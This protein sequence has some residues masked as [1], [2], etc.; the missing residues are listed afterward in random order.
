MCTNDL[1]LSAGSFHDV[2]NMVPHEE[3]MVPMLTETLE[4]SEQQLFFLIFV[5]GFKLR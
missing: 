5:S 4:V 1:F 3:S 2:F